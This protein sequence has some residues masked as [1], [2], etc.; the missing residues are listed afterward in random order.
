MR[1][2]G[3]SGIYTPEVV[4]MMFPISYIPCL[5]CKLFDMFTNNI[6]CLQ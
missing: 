4:K 2:G 1:E 5:Q 6:P 3:V